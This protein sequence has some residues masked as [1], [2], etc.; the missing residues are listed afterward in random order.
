MRVY[1]SLSDQEL[2]S[3]L[4]NGDHAAFTELYKR[5]WA[6]LYRNA[7]KMLGNEEDAT[8][9][10]QEVFITLWEKA[11]SL[12]ENN[13]LSSYLYSAVRNRIINQINRNKLKIRYLNSLKDFLEKGEC[14]TD[15]TIRERELAES[16]EKEITLLP[17][18]MRK[19]FDLSR[20]DNLS[21]KEIAKEINISEG[22]VKKQVHNA[23]KIL[24][25]KFGMLFFLLLVSIMYF[26]L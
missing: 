22:T 25:I 13:S 2:N 10:V 4:R 6:L 3:L 20:K 23:I 19:V 21:Y 17:A 15:T 24:R 12:L 8:D 18:K 7:R 9:V 16:I 5:Y 14:V 26:F 11:P 1:K